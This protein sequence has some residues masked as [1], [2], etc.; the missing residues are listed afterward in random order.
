[1]VSDPTPLKA[2]AKTGS[3]PAGR[4]VVA[5]LPNVSID[6]DAANNAAILA[7]AFR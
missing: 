2:V 7:V 1:M 3:A 4:T 5:V 6:V